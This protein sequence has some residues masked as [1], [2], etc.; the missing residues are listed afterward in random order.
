[1]NL[2]RRNKSEVGKIAIIGGGSWA[3]ALAKVV[4]EQ[5][6]Q[7]GWYMRRQ[8]RIDAIK[9]TGRNAAYLRSVEFDVN[10]IYFTSDLNEIIRKYDTLIF[11][12]PSPYMKEHLKKVTEDMTGKFIVIATKGIV[13]EENMVISDYF[14]ERY[15]IPQEQVACMVGPSHAEEVAK[16][17]LTYLTIGCADL[18][19]AQQLADTIQSD[20]VQVRTSTDVTGMEYAGVLK[21]IYAI[22]AGI[23]HGL[24]YG[25]NFHAV[26]MANAANEMQDVLNLLNH[27]ETRNIAHS[28]YLG[29]LLVTGY[30]DFSRNRVFG[31]MIGKGTG[32]KA[33]QAEMEMIAEGY[34]AAKCMHEIL[35]QHEGFEFPIIDA[36]YSILYEDASPAQCISE[37]TKRFK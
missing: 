6:G 8:D 26:Y 16:N 25:E 23:C 33:A 12:T 22:G 9:A 29:D 13:P 28:V 30:S 4:V 2:F 3:T 10:K 24:M 35:A 17:H 32:I 19:R 11:V 34:Y 5:T 37:L 7:I 36:V 27:A 21:N 31:T 20:Y 18:E 15:G 14:Q 1:M